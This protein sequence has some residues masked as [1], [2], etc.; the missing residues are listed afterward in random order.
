MELIET[1]L[2]LSGWVIIF[3]G[4]F[5]YWNWRKKHQSRQGLTRD[6]FLNSFSTGSEREAA[7]EVYDYL[8]NILMV[9]FPLKADDP[10]EATYGIHRSDLEGLCYQLFEKRRRKAPSP[11]TVA[12]IHTLGDLVHAMAKH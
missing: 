4:S 2:L 7:A 9:R 1:C 3:G 8:K 10:L 12:R 5:W 11:E 6:T